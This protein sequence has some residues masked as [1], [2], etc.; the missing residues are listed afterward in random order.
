M[1]MGIL[2]MDFLLLVVCNLTTALFVKTLLE[3]QFNPM[4]F[5]LNCPFSPLKKGR[6]AQMNSTRN[7]SV[8]LLA[9]QAIMPTMVPLDTG[10]HGGDGGVWRHLFGPYGVGQRAHV[11]PLS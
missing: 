10:F 5:Q 8:F 4:Q 7:V 9:R 3:R 6:R 1:G 11:R 2:K